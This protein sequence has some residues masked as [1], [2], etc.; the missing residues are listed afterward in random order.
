MSVTTDT[1]IS[2]NRRCVH[3]DT[4]KAALQSFANTSLCTA[5]CLALQDALSTLVLFAVNLDTRTQLQF[6]LNS[7]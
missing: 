1:D 7:V 2:L 5:L 3:T 4:V 6:K